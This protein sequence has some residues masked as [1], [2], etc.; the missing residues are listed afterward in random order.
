MTPVEAVSL[1][2]VVRAICPQQAMDELTPD[3][4]G[5]VLEQTRF[6]DAKE[7]VVNLGKRQPF[8][9]PSE[10]VAEVKR[11]RRDRIAVHPPIAPPD[12]LTDV[13]YG[14]WLRETN[15][16]IGDGETFEVRALPAGPPAPEIAALARSWSAD[17]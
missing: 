4:W 14:A 10:V 1:C 5:L 7:A 9:A 12:G 2:R 6:E 16:R 11:I 15:R 8:I 13:E 17:R 3:A